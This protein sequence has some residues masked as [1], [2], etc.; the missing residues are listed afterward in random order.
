[1]K[2]SVV[3]PPFWKQKNTRLSWF[4]I[5]RVVVNT[6]GSIRFKKFAK[7][8]N[9]FFFLVPFMKL[10]IYTVCHKILRFFKTNYISGWNLIWVFSNAHFPKISRSPGPLPQPTLPIFDR[11]RHIPQRDVARY[12]RISKIHLLVLLWIWLSVPLPYCMT[13]LAQWLKKS[14]TF[15]KWWLPLVQKFLMI[16]QKPGFYFQVHLSLACTVIVISMSIL[17]FGKTLRA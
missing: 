3:E 11:S 14:S 6:I 10:D 8:F 12:G 16:F 5:L 13:N 4:E 17:D 2:K 1:M 9:E 7:G 15:L